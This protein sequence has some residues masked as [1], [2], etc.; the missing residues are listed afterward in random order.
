[1]M[2]EITFNLSISRLL[3]VSCSFIGSSL[4]E[5]EAYDVHLP[6]AVSI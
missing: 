4:F 2:F 6:S 3:M 1:M 5:E